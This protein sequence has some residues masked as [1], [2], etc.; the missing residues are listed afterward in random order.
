M[1][2]YI[3]LDTINNYL[4]GKGVETGCDNIKASWTESLKKKK[5]KMN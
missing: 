3:I 1:N 2:E 5:K 4:N